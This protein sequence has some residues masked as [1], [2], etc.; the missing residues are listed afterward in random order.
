VK[1]KMIEKFYQLAEKLNVKIITIEEQLLKESADIINQGQ[2][3]G[4][5][6]LFDNKIQTNDKQ[7]KDYIKLYFN[8]VSK[9]KLLTAEEEK[10]IA[11]R[12]V[13]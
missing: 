13:R 5:V 2:K 4:Q 1:A 11:R 3:I 6:Q 7:Y 12:I 9:I 10:A 8:D